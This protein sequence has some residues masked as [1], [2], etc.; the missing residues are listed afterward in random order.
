MA[1]LDA[2]LSKI[3]EH[4]SDCLISLQRASVV[5]DLLI[6]AVGRINQYE[7]LLECLEKAM[8]F[9]F[10]EFNLWNQ[11]VLL[12][13]AAGKSAQAYESTERIHSAKAG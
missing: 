12:L 13:M 1:N 2:V 9:S 6:V 10:E 3:P 7:M 4:K 8:K 11:F 5:Y